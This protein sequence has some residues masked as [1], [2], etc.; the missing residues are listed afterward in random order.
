MTAPPMTTRMTGMP[1]GRQAMVM[2]L[3]GAAAASA[4]P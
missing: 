1:R 4:R 2:P 3:R